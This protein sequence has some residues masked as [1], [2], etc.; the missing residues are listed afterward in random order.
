[1]SPLVTLVGVIQGVDPHAWDAAIHAAVEEN[2]TIFCVPESL[3]RAV[4]RRES[5][6]EPRA[7]SKAG[8][9][10]L[11][12]VMPQNAR[13]LGLKDA[14]ELWLPTKNILAGVRLLAVLLRHYRGDIVAALIAYNAGPRAP[15][16]SVP[17]NGETGPYVAAVLEAW[18]KEAGSLPDAGPRA[19]EY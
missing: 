11:M 1:M 9:I 14:S 3:V 2:R 18:R 16:A 5:G 19:A 4:I 10:G 12:Q 6:G 13:R 15:T 8:A 7:L 17:S